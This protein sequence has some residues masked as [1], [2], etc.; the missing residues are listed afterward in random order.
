METVPPLMAGVREAIHGTERSQLTFEQFRILGWVARH[1]GTSLSELANALGL[2]MPT[3]SKLVQV[4]V[5]RDLLER[6][7]SEDDRRQIALRLGR[8]ARA[9]WERVQK[10][11][12]ASL[13]KKLTGLDRTEREQL[14]AGLRGLKRVLRDG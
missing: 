12:R 3:A 4:L 11:A 7:T 9:G 14:A 1:E 8:T 13:A 10:E 6:S 5:E 2:N